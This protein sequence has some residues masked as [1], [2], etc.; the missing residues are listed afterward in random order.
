MHKKAESIKKLFTIL[1]IIYYITYSYI[2]Y[3]TI[4]A[5]GPY[6]KTFLIY[7]FGISEF[8]FFF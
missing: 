6:I 1:V 5:R 4:S 7:V 2:T 8:V 3:R